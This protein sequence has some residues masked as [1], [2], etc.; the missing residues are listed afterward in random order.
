MVLLSFTAQRE[1]A[2]MPTAMMN[3][4]DILPSEELSALISQTEQPCISLFLPI[5]RVEPAR[6]QNVIRLENLV[7]RAETR[8]IER[9]TDRVTVQRMLEPAYVLL[10]DHGFWDRQAEGLAVF[11]TPAACRSFRLPSVFAETLAVDSRA[12]IT[13][14]LPLLNS[15]GTFY[16]LTVTLGGVHLY[17][18][19]PYGLQPVALPGVP[20]GL[21]AALAED[22]FSKEAQ[23]HPGIPGRGGERG[24]IFHGQDARD[25]TVIK[26]ETMRY[27]QQVDRG[28]CAALLSQHAPL[29]LAGLNY[30]LPI[31]RS[32]NSYAHLYDD[33][34]LS[35]P[36][37]LLPQELHARARAVSAP[38]FARPAER[39]LER[40]RIGLGN[41]S[42]LATDQLR[43]IVPAAHS[44]R[45]D[46]LLL[47][48]GAAC[49]GSYEPSDGAL[50]LGAAI[51]PH[52]TELL[53]LSA[54]QTLLHGGAV[55]ALPP[56]QMPGATLCA[57]V[58]RY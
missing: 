14:L 7:R 56:E 3:Q 21:E 5:E 36:D 46:S 27:F 37:D 42:G 57:A 22:E 28:V 52:T 53:N 44:G 47:A 1:E 49:W 29:I 25:G 38:Y 32:V 33:A 54:I 35:N 24:A 45:I 51:E 31:Y 2:P 55:Y 16:V 40:C 48:Q 4:T 15:A 58:L 11:I 50:S 30:L 19:S 17:E 12:H 43:A 9:G 39:A 20:A 8:L 23:L 6:Q 13:P 34:I 10:S 41:G 18:G 26:Q